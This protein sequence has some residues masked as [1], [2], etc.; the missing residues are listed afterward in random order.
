MPEKSGMD[1]ALCGPIL[2]C[3]AAGS[4][5]CPTAGLAVA[6]NVTNNSKFRC[7]FM[8][9][10]RHGL[11]RPSCR[12]AGAADILSQMRERRTTDPRAARGPWPLPSLPI[13][14]F[15]AKGERQTLVKTQLRQ[16][17]VNEVDG[18]DLLGQL[19][20]LQECAFVGQID[21][22]LLEMAQDRALGRVAGHVD[23]LGALL[24][25]FPK[26]P[27]LQFCLPL[28]GKFNT[29]SRTGFHPPNNLLS[30]DS[31]RQ[32]PGER[33]SLE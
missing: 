10:S 7:T 29:D 4:A 14:P 32:R 13:R 11:P 15:G 26:V 20:A 24:R 33:P 5:C 12:C 6:A 23:R 30:S 27:L 18:S 17:G 9:T 28:L 19:V 22:Q 25:L 31:G 1:A 8:A 3:P 21:P 2:A 16:T